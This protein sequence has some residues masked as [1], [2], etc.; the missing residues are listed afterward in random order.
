MFQFSQR[1][2]NSQKSIN[3]VFPGFSRVLTVSYSN[4]ISHSQSCR[5]S[6]TNFPY[7]H[8]SNFPRTL[9]PYWGPKRHFSDSSFCVPHR[10]HLNLFSQ[11]YKILQI[12]TLILCFGSTSI[13]F[14]FPKCQKRGELFQAHKNVDFVI[15]HSVHHLFSNFLS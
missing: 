2:L 14:I 6:I 12:S 15:H 3:L 13:T 5:A 9:E 4:P 1:Y 11:Q 10:P 7:F 8:F